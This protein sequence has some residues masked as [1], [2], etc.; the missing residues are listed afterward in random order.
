MIYCKASRYKQISLKS[1]LEQIP[2]PV[3]IKALLAHTTAGSSR[4]AFHASAYPAAPNPSRCMSLAYCCCMACGS[5]LRGGHHSTAQGCIT[6]PWPWYSLL[7]QVQAVNQVAAVSGW[8]RLGKARQG[9]ARQGEARRGEVSAPAPAPCASR[10]EPACAAWASC[11]HARPR[12][13]GPLHCWLPCGER[14]GTRY[15]QAGT[16]A[17]GRIG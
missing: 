12:S 3:P 10:S 13:Q 1:S 2:W 16:H 14:P 9:K 6:A 8:A 15:G 7:P 17:S 5:R 11:L 4:G